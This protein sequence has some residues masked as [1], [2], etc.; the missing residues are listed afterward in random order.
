MTTATCQRRS[1]GSHTL[2]QGRGVALPVLAVPTTNSNPAGI[3][4]PKDISAVQMLRISVTDVCNL[5]CVYCMPEE[6]VEWLPK[7]HVLSY[8]EI[9]TIVRAA[10][11]V[12]VTHFKLTGGE[13]TARRDLPVLVEML[14]GIE[15]VKDLSLTTNGILLGGML[16]SLRRAGLNRITISLDSLRPERF[17]AIT[18]GGSFE[19]VW[20][21][22]ERAVAMGFE[23]L[24]INVVVMKGMN[25]DEVAE[26]AALTV[27][28]PIT[29]RFIEFM[30]LGRS[31]LTE[32]PEEA[33]VTELQIRERIE[34]VHGKLLPV[35]RGAEV[36]VGPAK[37]WGLANA[38]GRIGFISAMSHPFCE[39]CNRLRLTPD[40]LMR[41]CLFDGGE[42]DLKP[43]LREERLAAD[44]SIESRH[45]L[46]QRAMSTCVA[47]KPDT[48][49]F[50][51]NKAMNRI[52]G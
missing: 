51:G 40:G 48:H 50:H 26:F 45:E 25:E 35:W 7:S 33:M 37:V 36:G 2:S 4:G 19:K 15:G 3:T 21:A 11:S 10:V 43:I 20:G 49:S 16:E 24:K 8:E 13:P 29:V 52:G 5:R 44:G 47:M 22:I 12:G 31:G 18:R 28:M 9:A 14:R 27:K 39:T 32:K 42:V 1:E 6:G 38:A 34:A 17:F 41:S 23:R 46:L 30:P